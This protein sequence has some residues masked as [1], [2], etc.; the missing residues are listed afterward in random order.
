GDTMVTV[1]G[2]ID[3]VRIFTVH[4]STLCAASPFFRK[5]LNGNWKESRENSI[6][7]S[8]EDPKLSKVYVHWAYFGAICVDSH[9]WDGDR[10]SDALPLCRLWVLVDV[11]QDT[12][13]KDAVIDVL[14]KCNYF[15]VK[16]IQYIWNNTT[17]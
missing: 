4:K 15:L 9:I 12:A 14:C 16:D 17:A 6:P 8:D 11:L 10:V 5:A 1:R 7:L 2:D 3:N 13:V